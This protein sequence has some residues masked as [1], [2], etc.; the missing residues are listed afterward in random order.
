MMQKGKTMTIEQRKKISQSVKNY[1]KEH[2]H[3][4]LGKKMS[5]AS[6]KKISLAMIRR[7]ESNPQLKINLSI[8]NGM[9]RNEV[10]LRR[11]ETR[12][13]HLKQGL[14]KH[15]RGFQKGHKFAEDIELRRIKAVVSSLRNKPTRLERNMIAIVQKNNLPFKYVGDGM[16]WMGR[17][18]PDFICIIKGM[19]ICIEVSN[20]V[21]RNEQ[22][23]ARPRIATFKRCGWKCIVF[24]G[25]GKNDNNLDEAL[26]LKTLEPIMQRALGILS[27]AGG[28]LAYPKLPLM[29]GR[30]HVITEEPQTL[31]G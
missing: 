28:L 13:L 31:Q 30:S 21:L 2:P 25:S 7:Y 17:M 6:R 9:H 22:T 20:R 5:E 4:N 27:R 15:G 26:V 11:I 24:F 19:K 29:A 8:N 3:P 14:I 18:N 23:Y 16:F 1:H 12:R 10:N